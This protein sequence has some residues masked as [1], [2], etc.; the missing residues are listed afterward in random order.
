M[1]LQSG[2]FDINLVFYVFAIVNFIRV[3]LL[4]PF[5]NMTPNVTGK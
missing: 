3:S 1:G 2:Y 4:V 5:W